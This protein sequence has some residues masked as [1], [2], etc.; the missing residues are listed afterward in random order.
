MGKSYRNFGKTFRT[1]KRPFEKE[2]LDEELKTIGMYGLKSKREVWKL[3]LILSKIRKAARTL[4]TLEKHDPRR[5]FEGDAL[6]R[7]MERL[8]LLK[9]G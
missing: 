6:L 1:Q 7:R 5:I 4:L 2:R 8:G 3:Q 9:E